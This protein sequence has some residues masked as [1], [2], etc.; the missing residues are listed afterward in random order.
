MNDATANKAASKNVETPNDPEL[1]KVY[2]YDATDKVFTMNKLDSRS[3]RN[4]I[5]VMHELPAPH[6]LFSRD[7]LPYKKF[8]VAKDNAKLLAI[9]K[10]PYMTTAERG[11]LK[12]IILKSPCANYT[13]DPGDVNG[14]WRAPNAAELGLMMMQ[15]RASG[16]AETEGYYQDTYGENG[17]AAF[18]WDDGSATPFCGTSWNFTGPW[19][20]VLGV[21]NKNGKW[22]VFF[23]DP[24]GIDT[25]SEWPNKSD[26]GRM[27]Q[28]IV[29]L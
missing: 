2:T 25:N 24:A 28:E 18:F 17:K 26:L 29:S 14:S 4:E 7:N 9:V 3:I 10:P 11:P 13:Q 12:N 5:Y 27:E 23:S 15:L 6:Y 19:G 16:A 22:K 20:R 1:V 21:K 8:K